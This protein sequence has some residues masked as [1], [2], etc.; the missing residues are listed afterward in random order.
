MGS[1]LDWTVLR[2]QIQAAK[3]ADCLEELAVAANQVLGP[4]RKLNIRNAS[5][6]GVY[7]GFTLV[8]TRRDGIKIG[9]Q[10]LHPGRI[11]RSGK[12][13][14]PES[15]DLVDARELGMELGD[16]RLDHAVVTQEENRGEDRIV[17]RLVPVIELLVQ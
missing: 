16:A 10:G 7:L 12:L 9:E 15:K 11:S 3:S 14:R 6:S 5:K 4:H 8:D 2:E 17:G 1:R 13:L